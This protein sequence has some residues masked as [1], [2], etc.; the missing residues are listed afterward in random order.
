MHLRH[1]AVTLLGILILAGLV[2]AQG[3]TDVHLHEQGRRVRPPA[4]RA[5][6]TIDKHLVDVRVEAGAASTEITQVFRNPH[7]SVLEGV[8]LFPIPETASL[9]EFSMEMNGKLVQGE[10]LER[11]Q[12]RGIYESI[13]RRSRDPG[14]LEYAGKRLFRARVFPVPARGTVEVKLRY[15]E[16]L[17]RD[18][19]VFEYRYPLKTQ[20]FSRQRVGQVAVNVRFA[21]RTRPRSVFSSSHE[22]AL[23][24][25]GDGPF[26]ASF[27]GKGVLADRDFMLYFAPGE[28][29]LG[30]ALLS[31][32]PDPEESGYF[33][34]NLAPTS[35]ISDADIL[36]KDVVFV[37]DT[38]GSMAENGKMEQARR[39][40]IHGIQR[41]NAKDRFNVVAF[42]TEARPLGQDL[43]SVNAANVEASTLWVKKL[44]AAGGTNIHDALQ[45]GL[46]K[47]DESERIKILV[48]LTD[49]LPTVGDT[50][51]KRILAATAKRNA[52]KVRVFSYGV[53]YDVNTTLLDAVGEQN[54]GVSDY[55]T[56]EQ[57]ME[58]VLSRFYDK[59][60]YPVMSDL[61]LV[62]DGIDVSELY[63]KRLPD[64]FRGGEV[65]VFGRYAGEGAH[66]VRLR[67]KLNGRDKEYVFEGSFAKKPTGR[68]FVPVLWAK[69]KVGYLW[70]AIQSNGQ[71]A[72]LRNEIIRLGKTFAIATPYTSFLVLEDGDRDQARRRQRRPHRGLP[73][74][75][76]RGP[77]GGAGGGGGSS[78]GAGFSPGGGGTPG[79]GGGPAGGLKAG[80]GGGTT[81]GGGENF[82]GQFRRRKPSR[83]GRVSGQ[84]AVRS[85]L[86][87]KKLKE[88]GLS[89]QVGAETVEVDEE[90]ID[91]EGRVLDSL[92]EKSASKKPRRRIVRFEG[93]TF[94]R[95]GDA[96]TEE[97]LATDD[98]AALKKKAET[99]EAFSKRYFALLA[100]HPTLGKVLARF[101]RV[102]LTVKG[103]VIRFVDAPAK[104][105]E[106]Q[107]VTPKSSGVKKD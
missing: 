92:A 39:S 72:E 106:A 70:D 40:L 104:S 34:M 100:A 57:N 107:P 38:S 55:V 8:Y 96:W 30:F 48:F 56:P 66:A 26:F 43:R 98:A 102:T 67:G 37:V 41:L 95:S 101:P 29:G 84:A 51:A 15:V 71:Q 69:R 60:A 33:M 59:I 4:R 50:N 49:G 23:G 11:D 81:G 63:P 75:P 85:A 2:S 19:G 61:K 47:F 12:A 77:G 13:V 80:P 87:R 79:P 45:Q 24:G 99:V 14:L 65:T 68:D 93:R 83:A 89:D 58:L 5:G 64:L 7:R 97:A 105:E 28:T 94:V 22:V 1:L 46:A 76:R 62:V 86:Q 6:V 36:P 42:S 44:R 53:G 18:G 73:V 90:N 27:E 91:H 31:E 54:G 88:S 74:S 52:G 78:L 17:K 103:K 3:I 9:T 20:S 32:R 16:K 21:D 82:Q 25:G 10:V 35:E